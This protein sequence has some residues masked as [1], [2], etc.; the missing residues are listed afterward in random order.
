MILILDLVL[1][2]PANKNQLLLNTDGHRENDPKVF[3]KTFR[4]GSS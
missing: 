1:L 2:Q 3:E 4:F